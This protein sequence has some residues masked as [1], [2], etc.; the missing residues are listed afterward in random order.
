MIP[1]Y[2][3]GQ[4]IY[5]EHITRYIFASQFVKDKVVLDIACGSG[6]GT[7]QLLESGAKKVFGID[8]SEEAIS[9]CKEKYTNKELEFMVGDVKRIPLEDK[10][11]DAVVSFETIEHVGEEDQKIFLKEVKRV[12]TPEGI[13]IVSTPNSL[14][15]GKGNEFHLK[16]LDPQ[17]FAVILKSNFKN[18]ELFYQDNVES[19]YV[20]S[21]ETLEKAN[22]KLG[23]S[24]KVETIKSIDSMYLV[25]VCSDFRL[26]EIK[27]YTGLSNIKPRYMWLDFI[28]KTKNKDE[29]I[30]KLNKDIQGKDEYIQSKINDIQQKEQEIKQLNQEILSKNKEINSKNNELSLIYSS[31]AWKLVVVFRKILAVLIP[32]GSR[33]RK[34]AGYI[35]RFSKKI[36]KFALKTR[37]ICIKSLVLLKKGV[38]VLKRDGVLVFMKKLV[39]KIFKNNAHFSGRVYQ[40]KN[41]TNLGIKPIKTVY[42]VSNVSEGG[43]KK[44]VLDLINNFE[45]PYMNFVQIKDTKDLKK[46]EEQYKKDDILLFQYLFYSDLSFRDILE[47]K[48]R[49]DLKLV[50]P[51]HDFYFL[52]NTPA[53]FIDSTNNPHSNY[54]ESNGILPEVFDLLKAADVIIFPSLFVKNIFDSVFVFKNAVL[55]RHIDY[56]ISDFLAV[57]KVD[58]TINI[59]II[60]N[61]TT[62]KGADYYL[63]LFSNK[64]YRG[65]KIKYH[66]FGT[67]KIELPNVIFHG[68]YKE[69]EIFSLLKKN[70]IHGLVFLNK[71]GETYS[72]SLTKGIN[73]GLPILY[74]NIGAYIERLQNNE[75]YFPIY[76]NNNIKS[77]LEKMLD[78]IIKKQGSSS[79]EIIVNQEK[80]VPSLYKD[81]FSVGNLNHINKKI[82]V[83][84][85]NYN[86]ENFLEE[87]LYSVINQTYKPFEIIF[88]DDNSQDNSVAL[89]EKI[90]SSSKIPY[91]II[92]NKTNKGC[93]AQWTKGITEAKGD[94]IWIA[95]ADDYCELNL[96]EC[97]VNKFEDPEV[98]L[99]YSQSAKTDERGVVGD[100]YLSYLEEIPGHN[101]RWRNDFIN[102]GIN[103]IRN[104]LCIK[105]T[106][107]NASAVLIRRDLLLDIGENIGGGL[108]QAGD[109]FTYIKVLQR[110]KIAFCSKTLNFHRYHKNNI[111]SRSGKNSIEKSHQLISE[112]LK[113]QSLILSQFSV[114]MRK[115]FLMAEH[116]KLV[117]KYN[118]GVD[119]N[120]F[121]EYTEKIKSFGN[122]DLKKKILFFST[123]DNWGGDGIS[124]TKIAQAFS[125]EDFTVAL[126]IKKSDQRPDII[127]KIISENKIIL[128]ERTE[129]NDFCISLELKFFVENFSPDLIF[130]SE[131]HVFEGEKLMDWCQLNGHDYVNFIPLVT[132][133]HLQIINPSKEAIINNGKYLQLSKMIFSDN[134]ASQQVMKNIFGT[135]YNNFSV[136]RNAFD[137]SYNQKFTWKDKNGGYYKL[138]YIGRL[139]FLHKGLDMLLSV[140]AKKKWKNRPLQI[141]AYGEGQDREFME[142]YIREHDIKNFFFCGYTKDLE[143]EIVK[144]DGAIFPSRME[145]IPI[146]L[147]DVLLCHRMAIVTPVGGMPEIIKNGEN[148]FVS[149][150]VSKEGIEECLERAWQNRNK[151]KDMGKEAGLMIRRVVPEFPQK[152]CIDIV[153]KILE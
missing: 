45:S 33:R 105:N 130:I 107:V 119:I 7:N 133:Q 4:E 144:Y 48:K 34:T 61:I 69:G 49:H 118:L 54:L 64:E 67:E 29:E 71:W 123:N 96:L 86:Y 127:E 88:L 51:I 26:E 75:K 95:E 137:V 32:A 143:K 93:F 125:L 35:F 47:I 128:F 147:T 28:E 79:E 31:R 152:Q 52:E 83:I 74:S 124:C 82:S 50:I 109:W 44:Y 2:N 40:R 112:T 108:K 145:G 12:L 73:S 38:V 30:F 10:S 36:F 62:Y 94:L 72:Y 80:D 20:Y 113:I 120:N 115:K 77:D 134:M 129:P 138:I 11:I 139:Y 122:M 101:N 53:N 68:G 8:I 21:Q 99:A 135:T 17:E 39:R 42:Y 1:E 126:C 84:I 9:Y 6:Y 59:G 24:K 142:K 78:L 85:P 117:C 131:G 110:S 3:E 37:R 102:N 5:L 46:Y 18:T 66:I 57:P 104:Y 146:A 16:E 92:Q 114:S 149:S 60:N 121:S 14:V 153:N 19:S 148:G 116:V 81:L 103:E 25:S 140:L 23:I 150:S 87:R 13:F 151:W 76:D 91:K 90:L 55:S 65:Y 132:E 56:K 98:G 43:A 27:E 141:M 89:A 41:R 22:N 70:N 106:I 63:S 111:V 15:Y 100:T 136:I 58:K 97:L